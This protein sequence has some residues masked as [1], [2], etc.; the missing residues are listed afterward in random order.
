MNYAE[1]LA[2][3]FFRF[4]GFLLLENYVN[5][6]YNGQPYTYETDIMGLKMPNTSEVVGG[7]YLQEYCATKIIGIIVEVK[8]GNFNPNRI[9]NVENV[10]RQNIHRLGLPI[11][12]QEIEQVLCN[13]RYEN[14]DCIVEKI[15]VCNE[16]L[17][18]EILPYRT[19]L[20]NDIVSYIVSRKEIIQ[21]QQDRLFFN[22]NVLQ[23][24]LSANFP[25][26]A[27]A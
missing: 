20:L 17:E 22:S 4:N 11:S 26:I 8:S 23:F 10:N 16:S 3:W 6:R 15:L 9:F 1:E 27:D 14:R 2:Y 5:H 12:D 19:I 7:T 24:I 21:K 13:S 18:N 25:G